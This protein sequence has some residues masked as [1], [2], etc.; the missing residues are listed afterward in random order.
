MD[1]AIVANEALMPMYYASATRAGDLDN[2]DALIVGQS[3][4]LSADKGIIITGK[5]QNDTALRRTS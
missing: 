1:N 2:K 5:K 4:D 3:I